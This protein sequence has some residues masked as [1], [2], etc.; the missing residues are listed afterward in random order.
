MDTGLLPAEG[1]LEALC[2]SLMTHALHVFAFNSLNTAR[3]AG[4]YARE[5]M[6]VCPPH[7]PLHCMPLP[8]MSHQRNKY[9]VRI[10]NGIK[11]LDQIR[12]R[13]EDFAT[14]STE[15]QT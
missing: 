8:I 10:S 1:G 14:P 6:L 2:G 9:R 12:V 7:A 3:R 15:E 4:E 5:C 11:C 13:H